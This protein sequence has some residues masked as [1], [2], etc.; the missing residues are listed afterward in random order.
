MDGEQLLYWDSDLFISRIQ[1]TPD[2]INVL[3]PLTQAAERGEIRIV[4]SILAKA[5]CA[6]LRDSNLLPEDQEQLIVDFFENPYLTVLPV[7]DFVCEHARKIIRANAGLRS[8]DAIHIA[9]AVSAGVPVLQAYD[10]TFGN[11]RGCS[12]IGQLVIQEPTTDQWIFDFGGTTPTE[13][14]EAGAINDGT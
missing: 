6:F 10:K 7:D 14:E 13:E 4:T 8:I 9:T 3:E 2:R 11:A 12:E 1:R 5:E